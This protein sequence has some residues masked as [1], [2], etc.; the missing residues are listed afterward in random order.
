MSRRRLSGPTSCALAAPRRARQS[1]LC[2]FMTAEGPQAM[3]D[4]GT[5]GSGPGEISPDGSAVELYARLPE[6]HTAAT[7]IHQAIPAGATVL[8]LGAGTGRVTHPLLALGHPVVAE[9]QSQAAPANASDAASSASP[10]SG[11]TRCSHPRLRNRHADT[12]AQI[13]SSPSPLAARQWQSAEHPRPCPCAISYTQIDPF[14]ATV[15]PQAGRRS[16]RMAAA[17]RAII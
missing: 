16:P 17:Q 7:V 2:S 6:N 13:T 14:G 5:H 11:L 1:H 9:R 10:G 8:E 4:P 3:F 15:T 12:T